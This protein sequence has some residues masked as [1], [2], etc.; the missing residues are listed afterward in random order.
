MKTTENPLQIIVN[1]AAIKV[2]EQQYRL[3]RLFTPYGFEPERVDFDRVEVFLDDINRAFPNPTPS[4]QNSLDRIQAELAQNRALLQAF[5]A[6]DVVPSLTA[7][8]LFTTAAA[9]TRNPSMARVA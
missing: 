4:I 7:D 3:A 1:Q 5:A 9:N 8:Q 6:Q 2:A